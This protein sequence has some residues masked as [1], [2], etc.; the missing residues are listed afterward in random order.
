MSVPTQYQDAFDA[1]MTLPPY[2]TPYNEKHPVLLNV[3]NLLHEHHVNTCSEYRNI[4]QTE[5]T[6]RDA[7]TISSLPYLAV[8]LFKLL[9]LQSIGD[10]AIFRVLNSSGT[11]GQVPAYIPLDR[12]TSSRQSKVLVR[13]M[14]EWIGKQRLPMLIIDHPDAVKPGGQFSA[15]GAGIQ[16]LSFF[17]RDHTYALKPDMSLDIEAIKQ[18]RD[19][20]SDQPVLMFGFT[21]MVWAHFLDSLEKS[22]ISISFPNGILLHSGGWKKLEAQ[23]VSNDAFKARLHTLTAITKV[24]N[25]YGMA[26][27]VGSV[28]VECEHGFL[29]APVQSEI[30]VRDPFTLAVQPHGRQG[31]I[32]VMSAIPSSYPGHSILTEDLGTIH[33]IDDCLCTRKGTYF[34]VSGRLPKAEVRG[35]SDTQK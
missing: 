30:I 24:H 2:D 4:M 5:V 29:H 3:L 33:G 31:L 1:L 20:Y 25:F 27:Q 15:R 11:T 17:G 23:K 13:I 22:D 10:D 14:Q 28:F 12:D 16:G 7:D 21:F 32:Q 19:K 34:S 6:G 26:E 18:F 35:C 8:R 9:R